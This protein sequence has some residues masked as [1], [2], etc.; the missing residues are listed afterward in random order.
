MKILTK[1]S[2]LLLI[3]LLTLLTGCSES[4]QQNTVIQVA[5]IEAS[6]E[7]HL[8]GM[9]ISRF[10]GPKGQI[11]DQSQHIKKFCSTRDMFSYLLDPEHS[12]NIKNAWVHDM[13]KVPWQHPTNDYFIDAKSAWYVIGSSQMG[14]MGPTLA[15]FS[16]P[17]TAKSFIAQ[18]GGT[19][20]RFEEIT[21]NILIKMGE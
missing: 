21:L 9:I 1:Y 16:E 10:P 5:A 20:Y 11:A 14:V 18:F 12:H 4:T 13:G 2:I 6:D 8:C 3:T 7:C 19:L 15:S 17:S